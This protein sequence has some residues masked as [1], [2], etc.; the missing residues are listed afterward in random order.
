MLGLVIAVVAGILFL[1]NGALGASNQEV[2][3]RRKQLDDDRRITA[4]RD[5]SRQA[6]EQDRED[7]RFLEEGVSD[8]AYVP[9]LLNQLEDVARATQNRVKAVRPI[10]TEQAPTRLQ[11]R[12]DPD[13]SA[14]T[15]DKGKDGKEAEAK[16][17]PEPYR[18]LGIQINLIGTYASIHSFTDRAQRFPKILAVDEISLRP[19]QLDRRTQSDVNL[20]D[21]ELKVTA[22]VLKAGGA[23]SDKA[24][25]AS[26]G[27]AK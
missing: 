26:E 12:R 13:A 4:R 15:D 18:K 9:T 22:F 8:A 2:E 5:L 14:K 27:E 20:L 3:A 7:L 25:G 11:Q 16:K 24:D 10:A 23:G 1:Q 6:L 17:K 19:H 21:A